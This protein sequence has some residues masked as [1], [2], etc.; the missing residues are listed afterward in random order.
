MRNQSLAEVSAGAAVPGISTYAAKHNQ[1]RFRTSRLSNR[2]NLP[3]RAL[4]ISASSVPLC[5]SSAPTSAL[6]S[7]STI[8][9]MSAFMD[10]RSREAISFC[11]KI[12]FSIPSSEQSHRYSKG[13]SGLITSSAGY[14]GLRRNVVSMVLEGYSQTFQT[15]RRNREKPCGTENAYPASVYQS[16]YGPMKAWSAKSSLPPTSRTEIFR[17]NCFITL[18]SALSIPRSAKESH[19]LAHVV[20]GAR[21]EN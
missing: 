19:V 18:R 14:C 8:R 12:K 6:T 4:A 1:A 15:L 10:L 2:N 3:C 5:M 20:T 16:K 9:S 17:A 13:G 11:F 7:A 21:D